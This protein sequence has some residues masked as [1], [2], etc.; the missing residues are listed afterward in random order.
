MILISIFV[1]NNNYILGCKFLTV[2]MDGHRIYTIYNL[3]SI[4]ISLYRVPFIQFPLLVLCVDYVWGIVLE[5]RITDGFML[6]DTLPYGHQWAWAFSR[7][8]QSDTFSCH[9]KDLRLLALIWSARLL[10]EIS[11]HEIYTMK[12]MEMLT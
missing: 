3:W 12:P 8:M 5:S 7:V 9:P 2:Q 4:P 11:N 1:I 10:N 6:A